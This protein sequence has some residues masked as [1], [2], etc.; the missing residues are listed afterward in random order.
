[1]VP[2]FMLFKIFQPTL[3][4]CVQM[5]RILRGESY[6]DV[7]ERNAPVSPD[8]VMLAAILQST[9]QLSI[10]TGLNLSTPLAF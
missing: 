7:R 4:S 2:V 1:M 6:S 9:A 5:L 8:S 3:L 10:Q